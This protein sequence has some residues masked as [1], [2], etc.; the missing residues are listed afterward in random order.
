MSIEKSIEEKRIDLIHLAQDRLLS[1][2]LVVQASQDLDKLIL[3][4]QI[5]RGLK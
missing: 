5:E 4:I 2:P 1:D 3:L